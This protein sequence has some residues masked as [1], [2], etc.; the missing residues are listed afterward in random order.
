MLSTLLKIGEWQ[1]KGANEWSRFLEKPKV[2]LKDKKG[3]DIKN[4]T[5]PIIFDLDEMDIIIDPANLKEYDESDV[6]KFKALKIQ[7]G[8]NKAIYTTVLSSKKG[9][10]KLSKVS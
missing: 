2:N 1:S 8:N 3:N 10:I 6:S 5:L 9:T 7:G 4:F